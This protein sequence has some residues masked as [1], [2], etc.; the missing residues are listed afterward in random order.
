MNE[1]WKYSICAQL[2][3]KARAGQVEGFLP[4]PKLTFSGYVLMSL[5]TDWHASPVQAKILDLGFSDWSDVSR[6]SPP[7]DLVRAN[8][9]S[10]WV[11]NCIASDSLS[12]F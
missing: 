7:T 2:Q 9:G 6:R 10:L 1:G 11:N 3:S 4:R 5:V 8:F 12:S